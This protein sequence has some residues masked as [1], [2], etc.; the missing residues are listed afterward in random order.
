MDDEDIASLEGTESGKALEVSIIEALGLLGFKA[1]NFTDG[2]SE[3]DIVFEAD[4]M[5]YREPWLDSDHCSISCN[6]FR[7]RETK[8]K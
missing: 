6:V 5:R 7:R 8:W 2:D 3:F 1:E 4:G